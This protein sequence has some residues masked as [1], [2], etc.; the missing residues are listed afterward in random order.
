MAENWIKVEKVTP[1][2]PEVLGVAAELGL[3]PQHAFGL[4]VMF[5]MWCDDQMESG[6]APRVTTLVLDSYFGCVGFSSA[7]VNVG[8]LQVRNGSL[9]VP[10]FDRHLSSN[11]KKRALTAERVK[12]HKEA[13]V[14]PEKQKSNARSVTPSL[15]ISNS[16]FQDFDFEEHFE[17]FWKTYPSNSAKAQ[18]KKAWKSAIERLAKQTDVETAAEKLRLAAE[19]YARFL[20]GSPNPPAVKYAQGWLNAER[21][22][23][24]F[25]E[26]L[27]QS[28]AKRQDPR[29]NLAFL[30][31]PV[32]G[33]V[34]DEVW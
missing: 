21:Y 26:M 12:K 1:G 33:E 4:C 34:S 29:G 28:L 27:E 10:N 17:I 20:R 23:D 16:L 18:A 13:K 22:E 30:E 6:N 19:A 7:L 2:K 24:D 11:A 25:E 5:W 9:V 15:S 32:F 3:H 8:W 31:G 14:T